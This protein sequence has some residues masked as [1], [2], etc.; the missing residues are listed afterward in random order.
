MCYV[1]YGLNP[2]VAD[3]HFND[4]ATK[5]LPAGF[6]SYLKNAS[7]GINTKNTLQPLLDDIKEFQSNPGRGDKSVRSDL[8]KSFSWV[9]NV[10]PHTIE[11]ANTLLTFGTLRVRNVCDAM[12]KENCDATDVAKLELGHIT[13]H[14]GSE[15]PPS[16]PFETT[17]EP[18][19]SAAEK[20]ITDYFNG[21]KARTLTKVSAAL[22]GDKPYDDD[23]IV[24]DVQSYLPQK[25]KSGT[26]RPAV[27]TTNKP[28]KKNKKN[29]SRSAN[30]NNKVADRQ[31]QN[32][33]E[34]LHDED[35][36]LITNAD[37]CVEVSDGDDDKDMKFIGDQLAEA[38]VD[39][40]SIDK[41]NWKNLCRG[42]IDY[43]RPIAV[44]CEEDYGDEQPLYDTHLADMI[45]GKFPSNVR[46]MP[47]MMRWA[48]QN[49]KGRVN[50]PT[51]TDTT[52]EGC[53][54]K[55]AE[56]LTLEDWKKY[57]E[58][59]SKSVEEKIQ[60]FAS[61]FDVRVTLIRAIGN[62]WSRLE[63]GKA[64]KDQLPTLTILAKTKENALQNDQSTEYEYY[65]PER[66]EN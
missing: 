64:R 34:S 9:R 65:V 29:S 2:T 19:G 7:A 25:K 51:K 62:N 27:K 20:Q 36:A 47:R 50:N 11:M 38:G 35:T 4:N 56:R 54:W 39:T 37:S 59:D 53:G 10:A 1:K 60:R 3:S 58:D 63:Y 21:P 31:V 49:A 17:T 12:T 41:E 33:E 16:D 44:A 13:F 46:D 22:F 28:R 43:F 24:L 42:L 23:K 57:C 14:A 15:R 45:L 40:T 32:E 8:G 30:Q 5:I 48:Y 26:K 6:E 66:K 52:G 55:N 61:V 18:T